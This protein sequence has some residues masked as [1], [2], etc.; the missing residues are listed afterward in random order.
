MRL[1]SPASVTNNTPPLIATPHGSLK[2]VR[3]DA[4]CEL[5]T[6]P[7]PPSNATCACQPSGVAAGPLGNG[8][9]GAH[10]KLAASAAP[11]TTTTTLTQYLRSIHTHPFPEQAR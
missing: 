4:P 10:R 5:P 7:S 2:R 9:C 11:V 8:G 3:A 6:M 1:L